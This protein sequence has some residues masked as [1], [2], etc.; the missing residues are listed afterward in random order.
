MVAHTGKSLGGGLH[1][2]R[3]LLS[4]ESI[5]DPIWLEVP[6]SKFAPAA[7]KEAVARGADLILLW[8]GDGT[9]QR[10]IDVLGGLGIP[11]G[12]LPAGTANLL[13][14]NLGIPMDLHGALEV[15]LHGTFR[16][17]DLGRVN[18]ERFAVMAGIGL[19]AV[20]MKDANSTLKERF[21]ALGYVWTGARATRLKPPA[22][23]V[24][25]DGTTWFEGRASC[26]LFGNLGTLIGGVVAFPDAVPDD[27]ALEVGLVTARGPAEWAR[28]VT[29]MLTGSAEKS[30]LTQM[31][32]AQRID[33]EIRPST[34]YQLDG[35]A[36]RKTRKLKVRVDRGMITV[37]VPAR[38]PK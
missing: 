27:G 35:G 16:R 23:Q 5:T 26:L 17:I 21:G 36:R 9:V 29:R 37:C 8:G 6:K 11:I 18:G 22:M 4:E 32:R 28:V 15:A 10:C 12:I 31:S 13:A 20:M 1:E 24:A 33:V 14:N 7:A 2:L 19:D 30:P 38:E 3:R 25:L 34:V